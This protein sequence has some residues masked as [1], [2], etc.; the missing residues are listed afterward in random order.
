MEDI[1]KKLKQFSN[2]LFVKFDYV[3]SEL[4]DLIGDI[5]QIEESRHDSMILDL[6][7]FKRELQRQNLMSQ[8]LEE[9][10]ENYIRWDNI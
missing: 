8:A 9:F 7:N 2:K 6:D 5:E 1:I 4:D 10:I 3:G